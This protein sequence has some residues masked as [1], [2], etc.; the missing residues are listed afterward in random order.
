MWCAIEQQKTLRRAV[1]CGQE[2]IQKM[3]STQTKAGREIHIAKRKR[4]KTPG[5]REEKSLKRFAEIGKGAEKIRP[6]QAGKESDEFKQK[7]KNSGDCG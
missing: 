7:G 6:S 2:K 1:L 4:E 3:F 5:K